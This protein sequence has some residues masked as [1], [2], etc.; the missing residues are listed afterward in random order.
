MLC[1]YKWIWISLSRVKINHP[2]TLLYEKLE[3]EKDVENTRCGLNSSNLVGRFL[4]SNLLLNIHTTLTS[5]LLLDHFRPSTDSFQH[6]L[7]G[8]CLPTSSPLNSHTV[9]DLHCIYSL[10]KEQ[11][12]LFTPMVRARKRLTA[13][14]AIDVSFSPEY[15]LVST[16][17][18]VLRDGSSASLTGV[19]GATSLSFDPNDLSECP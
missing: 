4:V 17:C 19:C 9:Y 8:H 1:Y 16:Q 18:Q 6:E 12:P 2:A 7:E 11:P 3:R 15:N 5:Q 13:Q 10:W 14:R